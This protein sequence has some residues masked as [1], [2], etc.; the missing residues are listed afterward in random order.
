MS[1]PIIFTNI[2]KALQQAGLRACG[3]FTIQPDDQLL[4]TTGSVILVGQLTEGW[5]KFTASTEYQDGKPN[6]LDRYSQRICTD[7]ADKLQGQV[8]MPSD[9]PPFYPF[10][11]W[12]QR[13]EM[14]KPSP[15]GLLLHPTFGLWHAYRA[16]ILIPQQFPESLSAATETGDYACQSC[17]HLCLSACPINAFTT[18]GYDVAACKTYLNTQTDAP[19]HTQGCLARVACPISKTYEYQPEH[20]HFLM[21]AFSK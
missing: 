17:S 18:Q 4:M 1:I 20:K 19:C 12:A 15:I 5:E 8:I 14:V 10:Q 13:T 3:V 21:R 9:G 6:P 2:E 11:R 16:A 7:I